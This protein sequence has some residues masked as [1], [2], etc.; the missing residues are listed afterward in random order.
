MQISPTEEKHDYDP[1][2]PI[3]ELKTYFPQDTKGGQQGKGS[4]KFGKNLRSRL[5]GRFRGKDKGKSK[6]K[7]NK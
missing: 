2:R 7:G 3:V 4:G 5:W 6:G 1:S